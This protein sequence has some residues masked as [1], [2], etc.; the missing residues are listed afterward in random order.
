MS[1]SKANEQSMMF[2]LVLGPVSQNNSSYVS[3][4]MGLEPC[5]GM[6]GAYLQLAAA[7][8]PQVRCALH[9]QAAAWALYWQWTL[10]AWQ[11]QAFADAVGRHTATGS[12][13]PHYSASKCA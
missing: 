10:S 6:P 1:N 11:G 3:Q 7:A 2:M 5:M 9:T 8:E 4:I 12:A 13:V